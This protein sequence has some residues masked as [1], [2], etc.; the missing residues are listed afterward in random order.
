[1]HAWLHPDE[2]EDEEEEA[3][4]KKNKKKKMIKCRVKRIAGNEK[5]YSIVCFNI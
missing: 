1:M 2:E 4:R 3:E 5:K